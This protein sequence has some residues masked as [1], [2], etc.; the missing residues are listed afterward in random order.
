MAQNL[1]CRQ[2]PRG[3]RCC[4]G[5][6]AIHGIKRHSCLLEVSRAGA[7]RSE[8]AS[9]SPSASPSSLA[10]RPREGGIRRVRLE[11]RTQSSWSGGR[12]WIAMMLTA[13]QTVLHSTRT[14]G[15]APRSW[16]WSGPV[17]APP[18]IW[19]ARTHVRGF[20][21]RPGCHRGIEAPR[22]LAP[23]VRIAADGKVR[24]R[25]ISS[26]KPPI[27]RRAVDRDRVG[28]CASTARTASTS[29]PAPNLARVLADEADRDG[30]PVSQPAQRDSSAIEFI[31]STSRT[32][33]RPASTARLDPHAP[34][35][36]RRPGAPGRADSNPR[37]APWSPR[38]RLPDRV[39][40]ARGL[41]GKA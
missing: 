28:P 20:R 30:S 41:P 10:S 40:R 4:S 39:P 21:R 32:L 27:R 22:A 14:G 15:M 19:A 33:L 35:S 3:A 6:G 24:R 11:R 23:G 7:A 26:G 13:G 38:S 31:V 34:P 18:T 5:S 29:T 37:A 16:M 8:I 1:P 25:A 36:S 9:A 2:A 12:R 17:R